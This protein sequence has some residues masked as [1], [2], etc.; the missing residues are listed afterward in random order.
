[1]A[2]KKSK[3]VFSSAVS[4]A[5][6]DVAAPADEHNETKTEIIEENELESLKAAYATMLQEKNEA[7]QA[8][9]LALDSSAELRQKVIELEEKLKLAPT[10]AQIEELTMK[11]SELEFD[12]ARLNAQVA[13]LSER[14]LEKSSSNEVSFIQKTPI[15][16]KHV[17]YTNRNIYSN[18]G[19]GTWR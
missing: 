13:Q 3:A 12:N 2:K 5:T 15:M 19:Y 11:N 1:M 8:L 9:K 18:N 6:N 4:A 7:T 10:N 16:S 17:T 14:L